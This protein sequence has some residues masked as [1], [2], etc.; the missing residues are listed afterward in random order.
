L[1]ATPRTRPLEVVIGVRNPGIAP[2]A[3]WNRG[4]K[5]RQAKTSEAKN[6]AKTNTIFGKKRSPLE[7]GKKSKMCLDNFSI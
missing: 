5:W 4:F 6:K 7:Q 1:L 3:G 2:R